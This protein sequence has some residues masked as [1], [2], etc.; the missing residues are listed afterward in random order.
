MPRV[1]ASSIGWLRTWT[2]IRNRYGYSSIQSAIIQTRRPMTS[3]NS[4]HGKSTCSAWPRPSLRSLTLR[5]RHW[6][7]HMRLCRTA[8][9]S[10]RAVVV[11]SSILP[12]TNACL[13]DDALDSRFDTWARLKWRV[14]A[15][16]QFQPTSLEYEHQGAAVNVL[17]EVWPRLSRS[18]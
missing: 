9:K 16:E 2:P 4:S 12:V 17:C 1:V 15:S 11:Y 13:S 6:P 3:L 18:Q 10:D 5:W 7:D 8:Q 14:A